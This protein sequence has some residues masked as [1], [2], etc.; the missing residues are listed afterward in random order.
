MDMLQNLARNPHGG[1]QHIPKVSPVN[2][3]RCLISPPFPL[4]RRRRGPSEAAAVTTT[5]APVLRLDGTGDSR[6]STGDR[7]SRLLI[8]DNYHYA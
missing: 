5:N 7:Q 8:T 6:S 2:A 1:P 3:N 4:E